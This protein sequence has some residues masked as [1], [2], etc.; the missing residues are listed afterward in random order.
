MRNRTRSRRF[1]S[2]GRQDADT[3]GF[4]LLPRVVARRGVT[5]DPSGKFAYVTDGQADTIS[6]YTIDAGGV[7]TVG[8][9]LLQA[10]TRKVLR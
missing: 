8:P 10:A 3:V 4:A 6:T 2:M 1:A 7:L 9:R 5:V